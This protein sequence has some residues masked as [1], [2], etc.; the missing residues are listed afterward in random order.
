VRA[1]VAA[2]LDRGWRRRGTGRSRIGCGRRWAYGRRSAPCGCRRS[3]SRCACRRSVT[4]SRRCSSTGARTPA[5]L[6]A[7]RRG[8]RRVPAAAARPAGHRTVARSPRRTRQPRRSGRRVRGRRPRRPRAARR[9]RGRVEF[10]RLPGA[11]L[12]GRHAPPGRPHGA[13][14]LPRGRSGDGHAELHEGDGDPGARTAGRPAAAH[15][16]RRTDDPPADRSRPEPRRR[17]YPAG[18]P[19]LVP[20]DAAPHRH[21]GQRV[22]DDQGSG[23]AARRLASRPGA[24]RRAARPGDHPDHL[25]VGHRRSLRRRG[26]A[27]GL[28]AA[29]PDAHLEL[30]PGA[31]HL[32]WLDAPQRTARR[33]AAFLRRP[34]GSEQAR[35]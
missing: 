19:R 11:A 9:V 1:R 24:A 23:F 4:A 22:A 25:P 18:V 7:G 5:R 31:G 30:V 14:G 35:A 10:R 17:P 12:G 3:G 21:G 33:V 8:A 34:V 16:A 32:P 6:G 20:G 27:G 28:V 2:A 29:M 15:R 13:D 26:V